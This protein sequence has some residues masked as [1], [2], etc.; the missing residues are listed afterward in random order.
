MLIYI[1]II[2]ANYKL[3]KNP[4]EFSSESLGPGVVSANALRMLK[5]LVSKKGWAL[6]RSSMTVGASYMG[7]FIC[8]YRY[9]Y[10]F[11]GP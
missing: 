8:I 5:S 1:L 2:N 3:I 4:M 9:I 7:I 6:V 10:I 11:I